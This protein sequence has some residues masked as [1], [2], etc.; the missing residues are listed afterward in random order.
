MSLILIDKNTKL[1]L[2]PGIKVI[3]ITV[4]GGIHQVTDFITGE[5]VEL[6]AAQL[7]EFSTEFADEFNGVVFVL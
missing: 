1:K 6:S 4:E 7:N 5:L 2:A 3:Q